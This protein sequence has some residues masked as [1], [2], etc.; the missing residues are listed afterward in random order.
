M[1]RRI[2]CE[3]FPVKDLTIS[4][5][6]Y[7]DEFFYGIFR[8]KACLSKIKFSMQSRQGRDEVLKE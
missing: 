7:F 6:R 5:N 4:E 3:S 1:N 2:G 8:A